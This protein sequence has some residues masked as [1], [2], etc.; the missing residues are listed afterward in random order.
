MKTI[1]EKE[2]QYIK[3]INWR[4]KETDYTDD[5]KLQVCIHETIDKD[6]S[7]I[8]IAEV[9]SLSNELGISKI[10]EIEQDYIDEFGEIEDKKGTDKLRLLLYWYFEKQV[11]NNNIIKSLERKLNY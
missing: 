7:F 2:I 6:I 1:K 11:Y 8:S 10:L 5:D 3:E 9:E 4:F